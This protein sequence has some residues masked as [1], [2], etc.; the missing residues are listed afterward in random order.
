MGNYHVRFRRR[1]YVRDRNRYTSLSNN[2]R[3]LDPAILR[4]WSE[5]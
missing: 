2:E 3:K 1:R 4:V 5:E